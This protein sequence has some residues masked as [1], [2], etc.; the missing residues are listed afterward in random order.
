MR[1]F[2]F[3]FHIIFQSFLDLIFNHP[4]RFLQCI[5]LKAFQNGMVLTYD[6]ELWDTAVRMIIPDHLIDYLSLASQEIIIDVM[7]LHVR[8]TRR[9]RL[10]PCLHGNDRQITRTVFLSQLMQKL[11]RDSTRTATNAC[12]L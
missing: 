8:L 2:I 5:T 9:F 1:Y 4:I 11:R 12:Q 7:M 6:I 3:V 10:S